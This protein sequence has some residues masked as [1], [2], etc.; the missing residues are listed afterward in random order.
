TYGRAP[1]ELRRPRRRAPD[2][3]SGEAVV[4]RLAYRPPY[5]W[6]HVRDFLATRAVP[7]VERADQRGYARTSASKEGDIVVC[8][9]PLEANVRWSFACGAPRLRRS[10]TCPLRRGAPS[11]SR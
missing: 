9:R 4:L 1:G 7:G 6:A 10:L 5:D 8:V 11:T 2:S 3:T